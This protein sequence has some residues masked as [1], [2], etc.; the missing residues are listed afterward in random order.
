MTPSL[1]CSSVQVVNRN[2]QAMHPPVTD[3]TDYTSQSEGNLVT[4][5]TGPG[6]NAFVFPCCYN[7]QRWWV[8]NLQTS[9]AITSL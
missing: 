2:V 6:A 5:N 7:D 8:M 1:V 9:T 4:Q 3:R